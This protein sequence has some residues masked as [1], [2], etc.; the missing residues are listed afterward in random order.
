MVSE[1]EQKYQVN[2]KDEIPEWIVNEAELINQALD[3]KLVTAKQA[4]EGLTSEEEI[5]ETMKS[6]LKK[7]VEI[8]YF[9]E[10]P[11]ENVDPKNRGG[12]LK[13][14][15]SQPMLDDDGS[16]TTLADYLSSKHASVSLAMS[17]LDQN[18]AD[19]IRI[20]NEKKVP[21]IALVV[22]EDIEGYW[23]NPGSLTQT[24]VKTQEIINWAAENNLDITTLGFDMEKPLPLMKAVTQ[25][26][27]V[28]MAKELFRYKQRAK[29]EKQQFGDPKKRMQGLVESL[30]EKGF[31]VEEYMMPYAAIF[32]TMQVPS[33]DRRAVMAYTSMFPSFL[34]KI[35]VRLLKGTKERAALGIVSG[36]DNETP[37]RDLT[38][39][40]LPHHLT[41]EEL[42][43]NLETALNQSIDI[44]NRQ[45]RFKELYLFALNDA[46]VALMMESALEKSFT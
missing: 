46:R 27:I 9:V 43:R 1:I 21:V 23:S 40:K 22:V 45:I 34:R 32:G 33:A 29:K 30:K 26:H 15:F 31:G 39:G 18:T 37:G 11:P 41:H 16:N 19:A 36:K 35:G 38:G 13:K 2:N 42:K 6:L 44:G 28:E 4:T 14:L 10:Y 12:E 17:T 8:T 5:A 24:A 3:R 25:G 20:L 7:M